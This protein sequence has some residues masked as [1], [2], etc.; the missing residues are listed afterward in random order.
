METPLGIIENNFILLQSAGIIGGF[1]F[2]GWSLWI[3]A[4]VRRVQNLLT[5]TAH[6]REIWSEVYRNPELKRI[7]DPKADLENRPISIPE[8]FFTRSLFLHLSAAFQ[9]SKTGMF[10]EPEEL[11]KDIKN[12]LRLPIPKLFWTQSRGRHDHKFAQFI[13]ALT[14]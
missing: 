6:H 14:D 11:Q 4:R 9:A 3:D 5:I 1:L 7:I 8:R 12:F 13:D 10:T 2:T